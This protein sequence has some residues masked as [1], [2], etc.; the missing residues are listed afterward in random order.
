MELPQ[1]QLQGRCTTT[2]RQRSQPIP[3]WNNI[4]RPLQSLPVRHSPSFSTRSGSM[5]PS[6]STCILRFLSTF[7]L[8][9]PLLAIIPGQHTIDASN[10]LQTLAT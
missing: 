9:A 8:N 3:Y 5:L 7:R 1:E 2:V 4:S 6:H 10:C